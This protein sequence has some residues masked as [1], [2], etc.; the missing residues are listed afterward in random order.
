MDHNYAHHNFSILIVDDQPDNIQIAAGMLNGKRMT[1][2]YATSAR[3]ALTRLKTIDF[4]LFLLDIMMP[5]MNGIELCQHIKQNPQYK[6]SPVIFLTAKT[7]KQTLIAGFKAGAVDYIT[8]PFFPDELI[9]RV[10]AH[11]QLRAARR[12]LEDYTNQLHLQVLKALQAEQ[13]LE[14]KQQELEAANKALSEWASTDQLTGLLNRRKGWDYM[15]YESDRSHRENRCIS[16]LMIDI[17]F[18]KPINDTLG[19]AV[20][21]R[22]LVQVAEVM[23]STFRNQDILIRWGGE[24]F[25]IVLPETDTKGAV[26]AAE[27]LRSNMRAIDW[28]LEDRAVTISVGAACKRCSDNWDDSIK[29]ADDALYTAKH[30]GRDRVVAAE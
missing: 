21:D 5:E 1:I 29:R 12:E 28:Q 19:H 9:H 14:Q 4:D 7:D 16:L 17:D 3:E 23:R 13:A 20:G 10:Q 18:F 27:K 30:N 25:L 22:I 2:S 6:D 26:M 8:K 11:L 15:E 24:E